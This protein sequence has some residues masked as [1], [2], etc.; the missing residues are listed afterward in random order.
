MS[1][2]PLLL[3]EKNGEFSTGIAAQLDHFERRIQT[4]E[5]QLATVKR[6]AVVALLEILAQSMRHIA[7]GKMQIP[8]NSADSNAGDKWDAVK[9][10]MEPRQQKV[11]DVLLLQKSMTRRQ[12]ASAVQM[13]YTNCVNNVI[14]VLIR[15]GWLLDNGGSISLKEL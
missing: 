5:T 12:I 2:R 7:S 3:E 13:N 1:T 8:N 4:L 11:I 6:D 14:S 9:V 10:R 15:Q